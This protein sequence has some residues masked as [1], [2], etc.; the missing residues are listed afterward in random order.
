MA[1]STGANPTTEI[2][3]EGGS[4]LMHVEISIEGAIAANK[5]TTWSMVGLIYAKVEIQVLSE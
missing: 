5:A 3:M 1:K 2:E 4:P